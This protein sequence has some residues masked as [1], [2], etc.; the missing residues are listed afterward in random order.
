MS[1]HTTYVPCC[2]VSCYDCCLVHILHLTSSKWRQCNVLNLTSNYNVVASIWRHLFYF[3]SYQ[4]PFHSHYL[5]PVAEGGC[6]P[7]LQ[8]T[9]SLVSI[10]VLVS[11]SSIIHKYLGSWL[12]NFRF[13][14]ICFHWFLGLWWNHWLLRRRAL[15]CRCLGDILWSGRGYPASG[16]HSRYSWPHAASAGLMQRGGI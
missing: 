10:L 15:T 9:L 12:N 2:H 4:R 3:S 7:T 14:W 6:T 11:Q 1:A 5:L 8:V 13:W 16:A